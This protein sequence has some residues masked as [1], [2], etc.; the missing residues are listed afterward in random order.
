MSRTSV[1]TSLFTKFSEMSQP[2]C[3]AVRLQK[4]KAARH[5]QR[6]GVKEN[7][8]EPDFISSLPPAAPPLVPTHY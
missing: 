6:R 8:I 4:G 1:V 3:R 2:L 5:Q 7:E